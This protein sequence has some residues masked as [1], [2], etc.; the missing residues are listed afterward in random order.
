[1]EP[2]VIQG[3][4]FLEFN[5]TEAHRLSV[6][7]GVHLTNPL[8]PG[9]SDGIVKVVDQVHEYKMLHLN[10]PE[11]VLQPETACSV[12]N[13]S[14]KMYVANDKITCGYFEVQEQMCGDQFLSTCLHNIGT[15]QATSV[16]LDSSQEISAIAAA[17]LVGLNTAIA[18]STHKVAWFSDANFGGGSYHSAA[19]VNY[20]A[21]RSTAQRDRMITMLTQ[22]EGIDTLLRRRAGAGRIKWVDSND[23]TAGGNATNPN[24]IKGY[25]QDLILQSSDALRYW[26]RLTGQYPVIMLQSGLFRAYINYLQTLP[27]GSDNHMF[28]VN[29]TRIEGVYNYEG[30]PVMEWA[31]A[32]IFD[33]SIG[34]KNP[35]TGHSWNQR[36]IFTV[37]G[38]PTLITNVRQ[39][40][41]GSGLTVQKSP[42]VPDKGKTWMHMRLGIGAGISHNALTTYSY[43]SSYTYA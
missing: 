34:L 25:L 1:M 39:N 11:D 2:Q 31:S 13:P 24:N 18:S 27:G 17:I 20:L 42:L 10:V 4:D 12:W 16:M 43:N 19:K 9:G 38:N 5:P 35:A 21:T 6:S 41:L 3:P 30:Y 14:E 29:G 7:P 22:I 15:N 37:P 26:Y 32:D 28:I 33:F 40:E 23:G 8:V 36:G